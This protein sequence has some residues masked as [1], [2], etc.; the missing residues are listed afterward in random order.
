MFT[1]DGNVTDVTM[2]VTLYDPVLAIICLQP[3]LPRWYVI[4]SPDNRLCIESESR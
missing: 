2:Y 1:C 3:A 4:V